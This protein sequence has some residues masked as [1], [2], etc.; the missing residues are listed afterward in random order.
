M[1]FYD[2]A[3][4]RWFHQVARRLEGATEEAPIAKFAC[5]WIQ[6]DP[7]NE[8][9]NERGGNNN[10]A[11]SIV[12]IDIRYVCIFFFGKTNQRDRGRESESSMFHGIVLHEKKLL[13]FRNL[14]F[15]CFRIC[16]TFAWLVPQWNWALFLFTVFWWNLVFFPLEPF[17]L[18]PMNIC[19]QGRL[20]CEKKK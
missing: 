3:C 9:K 14:L 20:S 8:G 16:M 1:V 13:Y 4:L 7:V 2:L 18:A 10:C 12:P 17:D 15:T 5:I 6:S 11:E 19:S